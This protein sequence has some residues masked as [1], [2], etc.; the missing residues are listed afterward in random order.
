MSRALVIFV[1]AVGAVGFGTAA[2]VSYGSTAGW[3]VVLV[4]VFGI[5]LG[6][7]CVIRAVRAIL[8]AKRFRRAGDDAA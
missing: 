6:A 1:Y 8:G 2:S 7:F 3:I 4:R 5:L